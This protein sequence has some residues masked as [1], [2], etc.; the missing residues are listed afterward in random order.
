MTPERLFVW[1]SRHTENLTHH[2]ACINRTA[3]FSAEYV[4]ED[5]YR[6]AL[7]R[8]EKAEAWNTQ[9]S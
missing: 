3:D 2:A 5:L 9:T 8:A 4:R 7:E 1:G 6:A